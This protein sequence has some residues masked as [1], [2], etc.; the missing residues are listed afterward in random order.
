MGILIKTC[1]T[2]GEEAKLAAVRKII[3]CV[4]QSWLQ[5]YKEIYKAV[6]RKGRKSRIGERERESE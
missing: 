4:T 5:K 6:E 2:K 1:V 3:K